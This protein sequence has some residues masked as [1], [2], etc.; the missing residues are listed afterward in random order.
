MLACLRHKDQENG[1]LASND[2]TLDG[3]SVESF[4]AS[5][6]SE[7]PQDT[8]NNYLMEWTERTAQTIQST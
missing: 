4:N 3:R 2:T 8:E 1:R 7:I 5:S 6:V